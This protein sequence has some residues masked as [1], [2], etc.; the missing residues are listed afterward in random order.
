MAESGKVS[1]GFP[2]RGVG[3]GRE[4]LQAAGPAASVLAEGELCVGEDPLV[5]LVIVAK[6]NFNNTGRSDGEAG[7]DFRI[8][9]GR[10]TVRDHEVSPLCPHLV[11]EEIV[12]RGCRLEVGQHLALGFGVIHPAHLDEHH[13]LDSIVGQ[14]V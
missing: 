2:I 14:N 3:P 4:I 5:E 7:Q 6:M 10:V 9:V 1:L 12:P 11:G 13:P 8:G